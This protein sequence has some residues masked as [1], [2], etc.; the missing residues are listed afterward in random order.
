MPK[1]YYTVRCWD[2]VGGPEDGIVSHYFYQ[3]IKAENI[4]DA[5][6]R[7]KA[8]GFTPCWKVEET[9]ACTRQIP[10]A[11]LSTPDEVS[12]YEM[13]KEQTLDAVAKGYYGGTTPWWCE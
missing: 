1:Y 12:E 4:F 8:H 2:D 3:V 10:D 7:L 13:E 9:Y 11:R 6:K 5:Y